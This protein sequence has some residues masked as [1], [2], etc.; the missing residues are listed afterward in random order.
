MVGMRR[1]SDDG[2]RSLQRGLQVL[3]CV[4]AHRQEGVRVAALMR[5]CGLERATVYR[6]LATLIEAGYVARRERFLLVPGPRFDSL[7]VSVPV[8]DIASRLQPVLK[9][10]SDITQDAA[11]AVV[12]EG[13]QAHCI[14][15]HIGTY[16][17]QVLIVQVGRR[18]PL[19]VGAAGLALLAALPK[20]EAAAIVAANAP[21]LGEYGGMTPDRMAILL[22][23]T[24][25]RGWS[26]VGN[27]VATDTLGVGCAI[28]GAGGMPLAA[29]SVAAPLPRMPRQRQ[30]FVVKTI[31]AALAELRSIGN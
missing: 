10:V 20:G 17:V 4:W 18:Q 8:D 30:L 21:V 28:A 1:A 23:A 9:K 2:N 24:R 31:R 11:F 12:R 19:G 29:I 27:H 6:L 13:T 5:A 26:V 7:S 16:P 15:R 25:E 3:E 22:K 14:A